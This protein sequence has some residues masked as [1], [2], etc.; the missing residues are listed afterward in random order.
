MHYEHKISRL[1]V[2]RINHLQMLDSAMARHNDRLQAGLRPI[3]HKECI[4]FTAYGDIAQISFF[5]TSA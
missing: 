2:N 4:I 1:L 5:V 3:S